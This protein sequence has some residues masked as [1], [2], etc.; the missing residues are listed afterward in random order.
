M[1]GFKWWIFNLD[2]PFVQFLLVALGLYS[3][4]ANI[5]R[6]TYKK[7]GC[8]L[9]LGANWKSSSFIKKN[10]SGT[11]FC[12]NWLNSWVCSICCQPTTGKLVYSVR[13]FGVVPKIIWHVCS[14]TPV[15][16]VAVACALSWNCC[17]AVITQKWRLSPR[18]PRS[19]FQLHYFFGI[20]QPNPSYP[21]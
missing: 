8:L 3:F 1:C 14:E 10:K 21:D 20:R 7:K 4:I 5:K 13:H 2:S 11:F 15:E 9:F 6:C 12:K 18:F 16:A 19:W 17:S